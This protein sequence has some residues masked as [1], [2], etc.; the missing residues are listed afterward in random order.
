MVGPEPNGPPAGGRGGICF[1]LIV[2]AAIVCAGPLLA[3]G[4]SVP[5]P[6]AAAA[7]QGDGCRIP[8]ALSPK[9]GRR[10]RFTMLL[11]IK[12]PGDIAVYANAD[13]QSGGLK[14]R[15][16]ERDIFVINTRRKVA[17]P[18]KQTQ[19]VNLLRQ[20]FPCNRIVALNGL[21]RS[22]ESV[23]SML[24]LLE[25][26]RVHA[27]M[28]DWEEGD[29]NVARKR[30]RS[31][32]RWNDKFGANRR[33]IRQRLGRLVRRI[34]ATGHREKRLGLAT[35]HYGNWSYG[36]LGV[37][38]NRRSRRIRRFRQGIQSV[39]V[40]KICQ[41]GSRKYGRT[42]RA[43][44]REYRRNGIAPRRLGVQISFTDD[45]IRGDDRPVNDVP[46]IKAARCTIA[47]LRGRGAG[48]ILYWA[49][50][51]AIRALVRR[52]RVCRLRPPPEGRRGC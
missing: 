38:L 8:H 22:S 23:G 11:R 17:T 16:R 28:L 48:A 50:P 46:P 43:L 5:N 27:L 52:T 34:R 39:Q 9:G 49:R 14:G 30:T 18:E 29:W 4:G 20:S 31:M 37:T 24:S 13:Q 26:S 6:P 47:A 15:L 12:K 42:V 19:M 1:V 44:R 3:G 45:P 41:R 7:A 32:R 35:V 51:E 21:S 10:A 36:K 33:R 40:Q 25:D 2:L